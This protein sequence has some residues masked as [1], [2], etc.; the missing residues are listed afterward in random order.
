MEVTSTVE[1]CPLLLLVTT[2]MTVDC[3]VEAVVGV[4]DAG[5]VEDEG[6]VDAAEL[7]SLVL[8]LC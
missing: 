1:T 3:W 7:E 5:V 6:A 8:E 2:V 4:V